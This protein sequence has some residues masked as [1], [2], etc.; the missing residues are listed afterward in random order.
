MTRTATI[1]V[2]GSLQ[3]HEER[4][5]ARFAQAMKEGSEQ[6]EYFGF[7]TLELLW[8]RITPNRLRLLHALQGAGPMGIRE[9]SR[10]VQRDVKGVHTD[11]QA[12][13]EIGLLEKNEN[14]KVFCPFD[15]IHLDVTLRSEAA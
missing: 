2:T 7:E 8:R 12:L 13:L 10:H 5:R 3:D 1:E 6:R 15:E 4:I 11:I 14:E 9:V